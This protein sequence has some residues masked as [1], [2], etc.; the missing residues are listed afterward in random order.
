MSPNEKKETKWLIEISIWK[1]FME[2]ETEKKHRIFLNKE[3]VIDM[4]GE[5]TKHWEYEMRVWKRQFCGCCCWG[6]GENT[7]YINTKM[8]HLN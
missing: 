7:E 1:Y 2:N 8:S 5:S 6:S 4:N 3:K